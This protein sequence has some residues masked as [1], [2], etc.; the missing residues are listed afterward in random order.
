[1]NF[2][3]IKRNI[4]NLPYNIKNIFQWSKI[5][6]N[7]FD[8]DYRFLLDI[9]QY[10]LERMNNY[11][12]NAN[13]TTD[14]TYKE[15]LNSIQSCLDACHHLTSGDFENDL[16]DDHY[17]EFPFSLDEI[18]SGKEFSDEKKESFNE[19]SKTI[20]EKEKEFSA[21]LFDGIRDNYEKWWD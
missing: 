21:Q 1:M 17:D 14:E 10:K 3:N 13:I 8:W 12:S 9:I 15:M 4:K 5:L 20:V 16:L 19:M 6:W 18:L 11:F 2:Y 7:N